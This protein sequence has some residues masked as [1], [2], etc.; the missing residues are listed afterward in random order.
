MSGPPDD[1]VLNIGKLP[2]RENMCFLKE[3][4][5]DLFLFSWQSWKDN[6]SCEACRN[7][8][9]LDYIGFRGNVE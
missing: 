7:Q 9:L 4:K 3:V 2:S 6:G 8:N 5:F 1:R